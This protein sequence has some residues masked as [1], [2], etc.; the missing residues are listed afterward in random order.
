MNLKLGCPKQT[1]QT[2]EDASLT[3]VRASIFPPSSAYKLPFLCPLAKIWCVWYL[4]TKPFLLNSKVHEL[5]L[6]SYLPD[7]KFF[8]SVGTTKK[9]F[10]WSLPWVILSNDL[11]VWVI[12]KDCPFPTKTVSFFHIFDK[13]PCSVV[14]MSSPIIVILWQC[15]GVWGLIVVGW[16]I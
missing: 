15:C 1:C 3:V 8:L 13:V 9:L 11:P 12:G 5:S 6:I 10:K 7:N 2:S 4:I 14:L 16:T